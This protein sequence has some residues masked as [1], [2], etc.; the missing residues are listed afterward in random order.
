MSI[1]MCGQSGSTKKKMYFKIPQ[2]AYLCS[3]IGPKMQKGANKPKKCVCMILTALV[4][5]FWHG[6]LTSKTAKTDPVTDSRKGW[7]SPGSL[8]GFSP[9]TSTKSPDSFCMDK[10]RRISK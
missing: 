10:R 8:M 5:R 9:I 6:C 1:L 4:V 3:K 7:T 2:G